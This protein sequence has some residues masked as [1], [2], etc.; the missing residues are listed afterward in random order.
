MQHFATRETED[1]LGDFVGVISGMHRSGF[2]SAYAETGEG[3]RLRPLAR[4]TPRLGFYRF[5]QKA[6]SA[7]ACGSHSG[8]PWGFACRKA[9][10]LRPHRWRRKT[11][12]Q[13][14]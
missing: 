9:P 3:A 12:Y 4:S 1:G 7:Y 2:C 5:G 13:V 11:A 14:T 8:L 10:L 6:Q